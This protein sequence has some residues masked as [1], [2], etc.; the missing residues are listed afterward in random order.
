MEIMEVTSISGTTL[1]V[2]RGAKGTTAQSFSGGDKVFMGIVPSD[3]FDRD[4]AGI[5]SNE[6]EI[7]TADSNADPTKVSAGSDGDVLQM[8]GSQPTFAPSPAGGAWTEIAETVISSN[9]ASIEFKNNIG[10]SFTAYRIL[11]S[12]LEFTSSEPLRMRLSV[13]G[14]FVSGSS[15]YNFIIL[16]AKN[17]NSSPD[18]VDFGTTASP[19]LG[20]GSGFVG[21]IDFASPNKSKMHTFSFR[22]ATSSDLIIRH[23][24]VRYET[25]EPIDGIKL[26]DLGGADFTSGTVALLGR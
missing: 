20:S 23:G 17:G 13:N 14:S 4:P 12:E 24:A 18:I 21:V 16:E 25:P 7:I 3:V 10:S 1:T 2:T 11:I 22:L 5:L 15:D 6:G 26:F 8:S 19:L 9:V